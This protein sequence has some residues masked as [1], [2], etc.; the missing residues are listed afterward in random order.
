MR[1][2][3]TR[4]EELVEQNKRELLQDKEQLTRLELRLEKKQTELVAQKRKQLKLT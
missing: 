3:K 1:L 4:F 2:R